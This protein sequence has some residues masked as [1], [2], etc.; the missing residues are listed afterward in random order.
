MKHLSKNSPQDGSIDPNRP[1]VNGISGIN[2]EFQQ[3][4]DRL[5]T[6]KVIRFGSEDEHVNTKTFSGESVIENDE[7]ND[8]IINDETT[9]LIGG[10]RIGTADY[11]VSISKPGTLVVYTNIATPT[12]EKPYPMLEFTIQALMELRII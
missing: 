7:A 3:V 5:I 12:N 11:S 8:A 1:V 9:Q 10:I 4:A 2:F 6:T